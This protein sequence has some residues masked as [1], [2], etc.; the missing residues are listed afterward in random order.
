MSNSIAT[1]VAYADPEFASLSVKAPSGV[2]T[3]VGFY[4]TAPVAQPLTIAANSTTAATSTTNA[5]GYTTAAQ[6]D[7]IVTSLNSVIAAL[8]TLGLIAT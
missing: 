1:G 4:G 3:L 6:A 5:Y 8:K 7:A 2:T